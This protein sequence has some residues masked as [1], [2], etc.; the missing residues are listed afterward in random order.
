MPAQGGYGLPPLP[1]RPPFGGFGGGGLIIVAAASGGSKKQQQVV[2]PVVVQPVRKVTVQPVVTVQTV[3]TP[4]MIDEY[5]EAP[6]QQVQAVVHRQK[7]VQ[8]QPVQTKMRTM[9]EDQPTV[10]LMQPE[11]QT[12]AHSSSVS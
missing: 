6:A 2:Q 10:S 5:K 1:H 4:V 9:S 7:T 12:L 3:V 11:T 8:T